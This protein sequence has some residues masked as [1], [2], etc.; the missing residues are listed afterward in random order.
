MA[1]LVAV[2]LFGLGVIVAGI[3]A[4]SGR[5]SAASTT[6]YSQMNDGAWSVATSSNYW[7]QSFT[8]SSTATALTSVEVWIRNNSGSGSSYSL[9]L[10]S[11]ASGAPGTS[12]ATIVASE[13]VG[14]WGDGRKSFSLSTPYSLAASTQYFI[15]MSG[16]AGGT[17]GWKCNAA[18]PTTDVTPTPTFVNKS[19]SNGGSSWSAVGGGCAG[20]NYNLIVTGA[21]AV[22]PTLGTFSNVNATYGDTAQTIT[23]PTSNTAGSFAYASSNTSVATIT[24]STI[25]FVG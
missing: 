13:S 21:I 4:S 20:N 1:T 3:T 15:V 10:Y 25:T 23:D 6:L 7:A 2:T 19:S 5:A 12:L 18:S 11:S 14:A 24:G 9:A 17:V 8:T 16:P 22:A